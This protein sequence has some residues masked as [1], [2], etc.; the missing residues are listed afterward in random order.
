M[1]QA[2]GAIIFIVLAYTVLMLAAQHLLPSW[3]AGVPFF[4]PLIAV[5]GAAWAFAPKGSKR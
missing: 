3:Q 4:V 5:A 1:L 2:I